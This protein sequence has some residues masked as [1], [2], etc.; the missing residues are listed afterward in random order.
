MISPLL[1]CKWNVVAHDD[2]L[3]GKWRGNWPMQ[4]VANTLHTT[5]EHGVCSINTADAHTSAASSRLNRRPP[6]DL[7]GLVRFARKT[8]SGVCACAVTFQTQSNKYSSKP[9]T[10]SILSNVIINI[11]YLLSFYDFQLFPVFSSLLFPHIVPLQPSFCSQPNTQSTFQ[12]STRCLHCSLSCQVVIIKT[13]CHLQT[14]DIKQV[15]T[16]SKQ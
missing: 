14:P 9:C 11:L 15:C 4:W 2:A 7:N 10:P 13:Y 12:I 5:S 16:C 8:K 1:D 6:A 3:E